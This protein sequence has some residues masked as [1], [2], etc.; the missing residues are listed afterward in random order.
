[1][2]KFCYSCGAPLGVPEFQGKAENYCIHCT[3]AEGTLKSRE[4]IH[5]GVTGYLMSWQTDIDQ[6]TA[7]KR[8]E[9][10]MKAM[11]AWAD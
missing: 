8:A 4:E 5:Q 9:H 7:S 10:Y 3:D 11:P 2:D 1:M 6:P